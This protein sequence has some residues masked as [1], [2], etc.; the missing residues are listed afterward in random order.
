MP[1]A[2]T[3]HRAL[4]TGGARGIGL[5]ICQALETRGIIVLAPSRVELDLLD[6]LS[7]ERFAAAHVG[8]GIDILV[9][10]AGI[11][12]LNALERIRDDD[13]AAMLQVNA[14]APSS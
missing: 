1:E 4:V 3:A 2:A 5:A 8:T 7:I 10:N 9:N 11:N 14:S 13:W 12:L 6:P